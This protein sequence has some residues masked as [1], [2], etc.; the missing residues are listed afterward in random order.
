MAPPG[1]NVGEAPSADEG[2]RR[3]LGIEDVPAPE[4]E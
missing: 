2:A 1:R 4:S 3:L